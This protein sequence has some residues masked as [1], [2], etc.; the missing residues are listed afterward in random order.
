MRIGLEFQFDQIFSLF[1]I[2]KDQGVRQRFQ[3]PL[4]S[5]MVLIFFSL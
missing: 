2:F 3:Q 4:T 1:S 5:H